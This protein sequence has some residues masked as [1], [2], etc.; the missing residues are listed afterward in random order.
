MGFGDLSDALAALTVALDGCVV[1]IQWSTADALAFNARPPHAGTA[2]CRQ[3][4][5]TLLVLEP[6]PVSAYDDNPVFDEYC[7]A[8]FVGVS[9]DCLKKWRQRNK[10]PDFIRY[11]RNGVVRYELNALMKFR[12]IHRVKTGK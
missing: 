2:H 6:L 9:A 5:A 3:L 1:Q 12:D 7:A 11:G 4:P 10:G 8:R